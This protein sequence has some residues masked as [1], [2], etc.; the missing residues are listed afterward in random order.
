[1]GDIGKTMRNWSEFG[2]DHDYMVNTAKGGNPGKGEGIILRY[3]KQNE[4]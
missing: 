2:R 1:L 4:L 3:L